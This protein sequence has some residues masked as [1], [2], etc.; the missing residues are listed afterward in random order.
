MNK[1]SQIYLILSPHFQL[2]EDLVKN[3]FNNVLEKNIFHVNV[4]FDAD[5]ESEVRL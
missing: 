5:S 4:F 3:E 1:S 2:T